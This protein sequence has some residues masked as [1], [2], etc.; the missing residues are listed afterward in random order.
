M[1]SETFDKKGMLAHFLRGSKR[2]FLL[3]ILLSLTVT[4]LEMLVPQVIRQTVDAVLGDGELSAPGWILSLYESAGGRSYFRVNLWAIALVILAMALVM[5]LSIYFRDRMSS[6]AAEKLQ[7]RIREDLFS[8]IQKLP[9]AWHMENKTGDIISRC[10]SDAERVRTFVAEQ[11][12]SILRIVIMVAFSLTFMFMM[13]VKLT[14]IAAVSVPIV[15]AYSLIFHRRIAKDFEECDVNEGI[16]STIAQENLTGVRVVRAFGREEF[17]RKRFDKQNVFYTGL[18]IRLMRWLSWFW[19]VCDFL[20]GLQILL[21]MVLG[22]VYAVRGELSAGEFIAFLSYNGMLIWPVR[23][24][25]RVIAEMS[26]VG[27][28]IDRL[29]YIMNS[30][31][32]K[33]AAETLDSREADRAMRGDLE[34]RDVTFG[35]LPGKEVLHHVS[36]T[37]RAGETLGILGTTGSG[38]S[39]LMHLL[40]RLYDLPGEG[41]QILMGGVNITSMKRSDL[42]RNIGLVLQEPYLFS[43]TIRENIGITDR[44]MPMEEIRGAAR[45]AC[46]DQAITA[47][48]KGYDTM[49][50]ERGVTLSG[51]QKQR[52]AIARML[53]ARAPVM[54]FDDSL[55]AVDAET[56]ARIRRQLH[57]VLGTSTVI[58]ISHRISTLMQADHVLV[59]DQG[60]VLEYGTPEELEKAGGMYQKIHDMQLQF[61]EEEV[62]G[63]V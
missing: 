48:M 30:P 60:R 56:D 61:S 25:G 38:K 28:S 39:T 37:V 47:F 23:Q 55:S 17:E 42:R 5:A 32:E 29:R 15:L 12:I 41:G 49:V 9:Y 19:A 27:V 22:S 59:L 1:Y 40:D 62:A 6:T 58:L 26:K 21:M 10:T 63:N 57:E 11:M 44:N 52:S 31:E 33:D 53:T 4:L 45:I 51:G 35:Y 7:E 2:Y 46:V 43:R 54:I 14:V 24:L 18:W 36:F 50:G 20:G 8:K 16:L 3:T 13:N 34:F